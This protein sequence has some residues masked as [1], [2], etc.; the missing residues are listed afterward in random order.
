M[1]RKLRFAALLLAIC[2]MLSLAAC[3]GSPEE[4]GEE[5]GGKTQLSLWMP[6]YVS[7]DDDTALDLNFWQETLAPW[8]EE[9][10]VELNISIIPW[11]SYEERYLTAFIGEEGPDVGYMYNEMLYEY[12]SNG[13]LE[14]LDDYVTDEQRENSLYLDQGVIMGKQYTIP[15]SV[16]GARVMYYNMDLLKE[17]GVEKEP[18]TWEEFT[19]A[20]IKVK[21]NCAEDVIPFAGDWAT[22][23]VGA[24]NHLYYPYMWQAGGELFNED[25]TEVALMDNDGAVKAAQFLYDL[26]FEHEVIPEESMTL[27]ENDVITLFSEGKVAMCCLTNAISGTF[28]DA[29]VNWS[30]VPGLK[31]DENSEW[32]TWIGADSLILNSASKNKELAYSLISYITST[33]VMTIVHED[34]FTEIPL[35]RD[36]PYLAD[37]RFKDMSTESENLRVLPVAENAANVMQSLKSNLQLMM[38]GSLTPEQAIQDTVDY[39]K[40]LG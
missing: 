31:M 35:N 23:S 24:L 7:S 33:P 8:A 17:A 28:T 16:G 21:E 12:I 22:Q 20:A 15:F 40:S 1:K 5:T 25:G 34:L 6:P 30:F 36:E 27:Q 32:K 19:D 39:A 11:G 37:E 14:P 26:R 3:G 4:P 13:M 10:N 2:L 29:G 38:M 18:E 9:N